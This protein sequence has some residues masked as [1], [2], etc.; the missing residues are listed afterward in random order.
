MTNSAIPR[1][2]PPR[3][4]DYYARRVLELAD[5][6]PN[7]DP[8]NASTMM[9]LCEDVADELCIEDGPLKN[10]VEKRLPSPQQQFIL[11]PKP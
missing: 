7:A 3:G 11:A 10:E 8:F 2:D 1:V 6:D 5:T 9:A 4:Y